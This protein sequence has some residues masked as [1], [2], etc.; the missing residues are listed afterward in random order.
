MR[1]SAI[2]QRVLLRNR[3]SLDT[4]PSGYDRKRKCRSYYIIAW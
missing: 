1:E 4:W 2:A 3:S